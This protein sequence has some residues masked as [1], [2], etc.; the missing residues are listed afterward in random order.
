MRLGW[1][2]SLSPTVLGH[3]LYRAVPWGLAESPPDSLATQGPYRPAPPPRATTCRGPAPL[4]DSVGECNWEANRLGN[5]GRGKPWSRDK[6]GTYYHETA[7]QGCA[8]VSW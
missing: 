1:V 5:H 4:Q 7:W 8:F 2:Y 3:P 6:S